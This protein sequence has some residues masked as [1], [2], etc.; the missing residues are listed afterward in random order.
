VFLG[1]HRIIRQEQFVRNFAAEK[2]AK[3]QEY[4]VYFKLLQRIYGAKF[5]QSA[6]DDM[7]GCCPKNFSNETC[8]W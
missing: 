8:I 4:F 7:V 5:P 3:A 6:A 2:G 1:Q